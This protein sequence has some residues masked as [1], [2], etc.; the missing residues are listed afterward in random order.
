VQGPILGPN[1][2]IIY[3]IRILKYMVKKLCKHADD[4]NKV[5]PELRNVNVNRT[6]SF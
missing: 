3:A 2:F 5:V 1:S 4:V 6:D